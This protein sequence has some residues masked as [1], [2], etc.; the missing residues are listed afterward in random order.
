M[1]KNRK[2]C[3][4]VALKYYHKLYQTNPNFKLRDCISTLISMAFKKQST[5][6]SNKTMALLG[7]T[8]P[9]L[10][11]YIEKQ[12]QLGM[13][14]KNHSLKGWHLDHIRPCSSFDLTKKSEQQK[15]FHYSN[16]QPLWAKDNWSKSNK[17]EKQHAT[18]KT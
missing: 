9:Q 2:R 1:A 16:Y 6:K 18:T 10:R 4:K 3:R 12:F 8:I 17:W 15:C 13:T 11:K 5:Q 7:C 14:W